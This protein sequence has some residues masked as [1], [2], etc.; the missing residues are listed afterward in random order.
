LVD[1]GRSIVNLDTAL[2][3]ID[4]GELLFDIGQLNK[5]AKK[6]LNTLV[7]AGRIMKEER[8][9]PHGNSGIIRKTAYFR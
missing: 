4:S 6:T 2:K 5:D 1:N 7:K 3:M 9:W 8:L